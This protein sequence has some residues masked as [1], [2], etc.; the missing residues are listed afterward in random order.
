MRPVL[1]LVSGTSVGLAISYAARP[2]LT[3]LYTPEAFGILGTYVAFTAIIGTVSSLRYE[4][5]IMTPAKDEEAGAVFRLSLGLTT[6][7]A[8]VSCLLIPYR[9]AAAALL[10]KPD[11]APFLAVV[12][13]GVF[14]LGC[15]RICESRLTRRNRFRP[16]SRGRIV[17]SGLAAPLQL[18]ARALN[19]GAGGLIGGLV[20]GQL[21]SLFFLL[22]MV[23]ISGETIKIRAE[24]LRPLLATARRFR[25]FPVFSLPGALLGAGSLHMAALFLYYYYDA[26]AVG[27]YAQAYGLLAAPIAVLGGA[28]TQVYFVRSAEARQEG[29][30]P[31]LTFLVVSRLINLGLFP[32][33]VVTIVGPDLFEVVLG[34]SFRTSGVFAGRIAPWLLLVFVST[35][36]T[37]LFDVLEK[38]Q[39]FLAFTA[40]GFFLRVSAL[41]YGGRTGSAPDAILYYGAAGFLVMLLQA[42]WLLRLARV[43]AVRLVKEIL[44][45]A[46][47]T[48]L[49]GATALGIQGLSW[50]P[51]LCSVATT[52]LVLG[53]LLIVLRLMAGRS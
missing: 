40:F 47:L 25:R 46:V 7:V 3:R 36:L 5:A 21:A 8:L 39:A 27:H 33:L 42:L 14:A 28:V 37:R 2:L 32:I 35:P 53:Y 50:S 22:R 16:V 4:D 26:A 31:D 52:G 17:Q 34:S 41:I 20:A 48:L 18:G 12:P 24:S 11:I 38:Q 15:I 30:L 6:I 23:R 10:G 43:T 51:L 9:D 13:V 19:V 1:T 29:A 49:L 45:P 44:I